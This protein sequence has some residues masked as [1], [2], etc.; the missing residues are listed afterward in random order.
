M[1]SV[2]EEEKDLF[3]LARDVEYNQGFMDTLAI[4][5]QAERSGHHRLFPKADSDVPVL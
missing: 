2:A 4:G 1:W 5:F 3:W